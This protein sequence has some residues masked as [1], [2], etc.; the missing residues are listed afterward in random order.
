MIK[1]YGIMSLLAGQLK[2][3]INKWVIYTS[4][5]SRFFCCGITTFITFSTLKPLG[6]AI[7]GKENIM[8]AYAFDNP[9]FWVVILLSIL[10]GYIGLGFAVLSAALFNSLLPKT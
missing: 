3:H 10:F 7:S 1:I 9:Q 4:W 8:I 2:T 6:D 5:T